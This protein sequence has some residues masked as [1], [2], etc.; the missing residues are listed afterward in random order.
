MSHGMCCLPM[1][2][3]N[4]GGIP[5]ENENRKAR[6]NHIRFAF[7]Y[8][9][10]TGYYNQEASVAREFNNDRSADISIPLSIQNQAIKYAFYK[11]SPCIY[12]TNFNT[13]LLLFVVIT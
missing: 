5:R 9:H 11:Q 3:C 6:A 13:F 7:A 8:L 12:F 10:N 1:L 4:R 2:I